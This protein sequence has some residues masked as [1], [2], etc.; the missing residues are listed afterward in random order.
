MRL[1]HEAPRS[2]Y[3]F[4]LIELLVVIAIIAILAA[5]L[6]PV[7]A[8]AREKARQ[9]SCLS[10][11]RQLGVAGLQYAADHDHAFPLPFVFEGGTVYWDYWTSVCDPVIWPSEA[12]VA[13]NSVRP[14][15]KSLQILACPSAPREDV[16]N[17]YA[18][19][20]AWNA[21]SFN[22]YLSGNA[23]SVVREPAQTFMWSEAMGRNFGSATIQ[24]P[25]YTR[26]MA[27]PYP[28]TDWYVPFSNQ[29][30]DGGAIY[31]ANMASVDMRLHNEGM[32]YAYA[33]G[34]SKWQREGSPGGTYSRLAPDGTVLALWVW[35][36]GLANYNPFWER[37]MG[38]AVCTG[39]A[40]CPNCTRH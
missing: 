11:T 39:G 21:Y 5:I 38:S 29:P 1:A 35:G 18:A 15:T 24:F 12:M 20:P 22:T 13:N 31:W 3:G 10:N 6:F 30:G 33:D 40:G 14:Y 27:D 34:H 9:T 23:E 36:H 32:N 19:G 16:Y 26:Y 8:K 4:T 37:S 28:Q 2:R 7:F 17:A 25:I